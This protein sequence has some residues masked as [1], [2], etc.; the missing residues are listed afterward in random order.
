MKKQTKTKSEIFRAKQQDFTTGDS[1]A[2]HGWY[3]VKYSRPKNKSEI[4]YGLGRY[5]RKWG[6]DV[7]SKKGAF[8][9]PP[10]VHAHARIDLG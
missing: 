2:T 3:I 10:T 9:L 4:Y 8:A 5:T 1:P 7:Y 6:W